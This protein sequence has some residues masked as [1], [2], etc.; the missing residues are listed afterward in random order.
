[1]GSDSDKRALSQPGSAPRF[2]I[3]RVCVRPSVRRLAP[4]VRSDP[5]WPTARKR[6]NASR[7]DAPKQI[8]N[9]RVRLRYDRDMDMMATA[10][11]LCILVGHH[12]IRQKKQTN[13]HSFRRRTKKR[14]GGE[15]PG[16]GSIPRRPNSTIKF[17]ASIPHVRS[18]R[19]HT[20]KTHTQ[21]SQKQ[22]AQM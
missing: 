19:F 8:S 4:D 22:Q 18:S 21:T 12:Q 6:S 1:M 15:G 7:A 5:I 20:P 11:P 2:S 14:R 9:S 13:K 16:P 17:S 10:A 3:L